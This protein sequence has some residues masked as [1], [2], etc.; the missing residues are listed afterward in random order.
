MRLPAIRRARALLAF[1]VVLAGTAASADPPAQ[2]LAKAGACPSG[3]S[4]SGA[5]CL[6]TSR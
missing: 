4:T 3:Y 2:P 6:R 5:Y 1:L